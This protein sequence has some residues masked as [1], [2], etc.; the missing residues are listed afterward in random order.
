MNY[1]KKRIPST[2]ILGI[3]LIIALIFTGLIL[4]ISWAALQAE[5][6]DQ[7]EVAGSIALVF[8]GA[9][10]IAL[11]ILFAGAVN[12]LSGVCLIFTIKNRQSTL[13]P[14]RIISYVMDGLFGFVILATLVKIILL[15]VGV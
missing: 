6:Q 2:I 9:I 1:D 3:A 11:I 7:E 4:S 12:I 5:A 15:I 10:G 14:I 8:V 13:K